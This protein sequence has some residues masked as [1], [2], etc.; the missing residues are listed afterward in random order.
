MPDSKARLRRIERT[1][2]LSHEFT[3]TL[4]REA[5]LRRTVQVAADLLA[6]ES[7]GIL[8]WDERANN[9]RFVAATLF[10]DQ[11]LDI[12]VPID[13][14]IAGAA[15]A[16]AQPVV[17]NDVARD[18]RYYLPV[19]EAIGMPARSLLAV[20]LQFRDAKIGVLEAENKK[21]HREFDAWD[22]ETLTALA[23]QVTIAIENA[24]LYERAQAEIAA[25]ARAEDALRQQRD[26]LQVHVAERTRELSLLYDLSALATRMQSLEALLHSSLTHLTTVLQCSAGI[27]FLAAERRKVEKPVRLQVVAQRGIPPN[28]TLLDGMYPSEDG[29][30]AALQA[31]QHPLLIANIAAD[32]RVPPAMRALGAQAML[33]SPLQTSEQLLGVVGVLRDA[34][35]EFTPEESAL[36]ATVTSQVSV[37]VQSQR[38]RQLAQQSALQEERQRLARDLHDSVTQSLYS[39]T[40]FAQA[41]RS[42]VF[43]GNLAL[44]QQY[45]GRLSEIAQQA[46]K[47]MR[48]L[49]YELR[50][51]L[52]EEVGLV[53]ALQRRLEM[54]ERRAGVEAQLVIGEMRELETTLEDTVYQIAQEALNNTLKHAAAN[55]VIVRLN[56][57]VRSLR[58]EIQDDGK[59]F[60][61]V[62]AEKAA[63]LGLASMRERAK[64]LGGTLTVTSKS[65]QGGTRVHLVVPLNKEKLQ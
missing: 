13:A 40:L 41:S 28:L 43:A 16:S 65:G 34:A 30:F 9:L 5:I 32:P 37:A 45:V 18:P 56:T 50:P 61:P 47:E 25:R 64:Q 54:V 44:T 1:L 6:C 10:Q 11:L 35:Q 4:S 46:L 7:V 17:V 14:S 60:D 3:S 19:A 48:W 22:V 12:P 29:L 31:Q 26:R 38:L 15:F 27:V 23:A 52:V 57:D 62:S 2:A 8:L 55:F 33:L 39:V 36:L 24:R 58:L 42:A 51:A 63:G 49:I 21:R 59:G 20:P 53:D